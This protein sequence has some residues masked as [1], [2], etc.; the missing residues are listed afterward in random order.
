MT[1]FINVPVPAHLVTEVMAYIARRTS[2]DRQTAPEADRHDEEPTMV[3]NRYGRFPDWPIDRLRQV[4]ISAEPGPQMV[5]DMLDILEG[6]PGERVP[7]SELAAATGRGPDSVKS[8]LA[9]FTKWVKKELDDQT[10]PR[11]WPVNYQAR[12]GQQVAKETHY[13]ITA[14]TA[15]RWR[16]LR[17]DA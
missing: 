11:N 4:R 14:V 7:L 16:Q 15:E 2:T 3:G 8:S 1:D 17:R 9:A 13:W 6:R 5:A 10:E 12:P